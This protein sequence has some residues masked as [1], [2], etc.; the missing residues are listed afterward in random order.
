MVTFSVGD[1]VIGEARGADVVTPL[2]LVSGATDE[3]DTQ[4]TN[5]IR[6]LQSLD[7]DGD[8]ANGITIAEG[9][10]NSLTGQS[11]DF[12]LPIG[13]F[14][15]AFNIM[16]DTVLG[17]MRLVDVDAARTH[18][19]NA[20]DQLAGGGGYAGNN[21]YGGVSLRGVDVDKI[22]SLYEPEMV[23]VYPSD[24]SFSVSWTGGN[25]KPENVGHVTGISASRIGNDIQILQLS[26][27]DYRNESE[28]ISYIYNIQCYPIKAP[29]CSKVI[30]DETNKRLIINSVTLTP[31]D[32]SIVTNSATGPVAVSGTLYW[33]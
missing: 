22:G 33:E 2:D 12:S 25:S 13:N 3:N 9:V 18:F 21:K 6:F 20:L 7:D 1:I 32:S 26:V 15:A 11:L 5:I 14:E 28:L 27:Q 4:V 19:R 10:H 29:D 31:F 8:L 17:A 24:I 30:L 23:S 16:S